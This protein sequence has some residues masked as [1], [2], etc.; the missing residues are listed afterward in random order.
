MLGGVGWVDILFQNRKLEKICNSDSL[1]K[2]TYGIVCSKKIRRRLD[3][4]RAAENLEVLRSL[5]QVRCHELK[6]NREGTLAVDLEHPQR[7]I[8]ESANDPIPRKP[9]GGLD[10]MGITAIRVLSVEDY[11]QEP[12]S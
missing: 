1:L 4:F 2:Q 5:P 9:D 10:W 11:R 7:L 8:F 12:H 6:G 3:E